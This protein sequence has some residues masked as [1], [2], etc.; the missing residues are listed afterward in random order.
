MHCFQNILVGVDLTRC[1]Q[2]DVSELGLNAREAINHAIWLANRNSAKLLLFSVLPLSREAIHQ[3]RTDG[4]PH[5]G[6]TIEERVNTLLAAFVE[7][8]AQQGVQASSQL[9]P[10]QAVPEIINQVKRGQHDLV[11]A[12]IRNQTWLS[13]LL[14]GNT[15]FT[16][17]HHCP[18]PVWVAKPGLP[19]LPRNILIATDLKE[20]GIAGVRLGIPL[21]RLLGSTI[22]VLHAVE[23]PLD[24]LWAPATPDAHTQA[25]H[26]KLRATAQQTLHE[27]VCGADLQ[28]HEADIQVHL[29]DSARDVDHVIQRFIEEHDI[30]LLIK[31]TVERSGVDGLMMGNTAVRLL[32][33]VHCSV[34][35]VR[36]AVPGS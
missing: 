18:C 28:G 23:Y 8:A 5:S 31:G 10:G 12:G 7:Q 35:A 22:H 9:V 24:F 26:A 34:L 19:G 36:P 30:D 16:L 2:F 11:V 3:V 33:E 4:S 29:P 25:Y 15:A 6:R 14:F 20:S 17:L 21:G 32:P 1:R 27:Q 13:R